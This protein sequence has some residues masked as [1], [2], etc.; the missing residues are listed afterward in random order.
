MHGQMV[1]VAKEKISLPASYGGIMRYDES[2]A[3]IQ[4]EPG[5]V[6][7]ITLLVSVLILLLHFL[8]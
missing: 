6:V 8:K 2:V 1:K 3:E 4:M 7:V 5:H